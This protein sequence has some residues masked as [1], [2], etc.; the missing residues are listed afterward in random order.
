MNLC[1]APK[2]PV[3]KAREILRAGGLDVT[4]EEAACIL[5]FMSRIAAISYEI[6]FLKTPES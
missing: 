5:A 6:Y 3:A 2:I 1:E 4:M